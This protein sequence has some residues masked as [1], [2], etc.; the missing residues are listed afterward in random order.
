MYKRQEFTLA[1]AP[2][3]IAALEQLPSRTGWLEL[4]LLELQSFQLEE[5]LV[6][7]AQAAVSYTHLDVYKRQLST[8]A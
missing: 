3:R 5:H 8:L 6:F 1:G 4:N 2:Q 7:S